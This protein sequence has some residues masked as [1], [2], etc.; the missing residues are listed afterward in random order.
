MKL[1]K[2]LLSLLLALAMVLTLAAC[3]KDD[4]GGKKSSEGDKDVSEE[5]KESEDEKEPETPE[6]DE[7]PIEIPESEEFDF[8]VVAFSSRE[9]QI[10]AGTDIK[11]GGNMDNE[12]GGAEDAIRIVGFQGYAEPAGG[13][14]DGSS[15]MW[16]HLISQNGEFWENISRIEADFF[17]EGLN[18]FEPEE[19]SMI[20]TFIQGGGL[21]GHKWSNSGYNMLWDFDPDNDEYYDTERGADGFK[22]GHVLTAV[23]DIDAWK[24]KMSD[25]MGEK[26]DTNFPLPAT[27]EDPAKPDGKKLGGGVLKFGLMVKTDN[28]L[29]DVDAKISWTDVT[30]YVYDLELFNKFVKEVEEETGK[31]MSENAVGR[32]IE[33]S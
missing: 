27:L 10:P 5:A 9:F 26:F 12:G 14:P 24:V 13:Y 32:V 11:V 31:T 33:V 19:I 25:E 4:E 20:E 22:W 2:R 23:W 30:F 17:L 18:D 8:G 28:I 21:L 15:N 16:Q 29:D 1:N 7:E 6:K 3:Q